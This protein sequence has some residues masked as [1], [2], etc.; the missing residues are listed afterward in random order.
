MEKLSKIKNFLDKELK[1]KSIEDSSKNGLQVKSNKE[2]KKIGFAVDACMST[3]ERAKKSKVDLLIVHHGIK[4][5]GLKDSMQ[6]KKK[7]YI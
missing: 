6:L 1:I 4:W 3:I 2:I 7:T 5:A